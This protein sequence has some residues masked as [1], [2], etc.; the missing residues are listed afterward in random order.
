MKRLAVIALLFTLLV[1]S[2]SVA[3]IVI[4]WNPLPGSYPVDVFILNPTTFAYDFVVGASDLLVTDLG[5]RDN[6]LD[7]LVY[8]HDVSIWR[9]DGTP[10]ADATVPSGTVAP[11]DGEFRYTDLFAPVLLES[12]QTYVIG[13]WYPDI[14]DVAYSWTSWDPVGHPDFASLGAN[15]AT[16][17][18][19]ALV[20]PGAFNNTGP[21]LG[22]SFQ[23]NVVPEPGTLALFLIGG[24]TAALSRIKRW[25]APSGSRGVISSPRPHHRTCGSAS[26]GS[27]GL[28]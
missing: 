23:Y 22:P 5:I 1:C 3:S 28:P 27:E 4:S 7:G 13:M 14:E 12:G 11:L 16:V 18:S 24:A 17:Q 25:R 26:G 6:G 15:G 10:V 8:S 20:F 19:D 21:F 9:A 2:R